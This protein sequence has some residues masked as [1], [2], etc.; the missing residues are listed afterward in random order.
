MNLSVQRRLW[1]C[2]L[3]QEFALGFKP[4]G[5]VHQSIQVGVRRRSVGNKLILSV[6]RDLAADEG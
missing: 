6:Y 2:A 5:I 1:L 4:I 3:E